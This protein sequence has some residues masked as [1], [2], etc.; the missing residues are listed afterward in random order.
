MNTNPRRSNCGFTLVEMLV[1]IALATILVVLAAPNLFGYVAKKRV[2]G[3]MSE[4]GTDLQFARSEAVARNVD[5]RVTLG[6]NCYVIHLDSATA[7]SCT[8]T[9]KTITPANAEIKTV[10]LDASS[11]SLTQTA[12]S[13][14]FDA[15]RGARIA[16]TG[17]GDPARIDVA[18]TTGSWHISVCISAVGRNAIFS[19]TGAGHVSGYPTSCPTT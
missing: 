16:T 18:S 14:T 4:L 13:V 3:V 1:V 10:Q 17:L 11:A 6:P 15:V 8:Q 19:A 12:G 2:E 7:A 5:V 9:T